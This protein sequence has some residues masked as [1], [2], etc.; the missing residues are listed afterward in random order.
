MTQD[1][2]CED[3]SERQLGALVASLAA[4]LIEGV[5]NVAV[6]PAEPVPAGAG[7]RRI[8]E[9]ADLIKAQ[10]AAVNRTREVAESAARVSEA[11]SKALDAVR[12]NLEKTRESQ[13]K[14]RDTADKTRTAAEA[15]RTQSEKLALVAERA[16]T[17]AN[18]A[19]MESALAKEAGTQAS[20]LAGKTLQSIEHLNGISG[21][22]RSVLTSV[23][24]L[25]TAAEQTQQA[26]TRNA[27]TSAELLKLAE[28][29]RAAASNTLLT[30][31]QALRVLKE[32]DARRSLSRRRKITA[33][34]LGGLAAATLATAVTLSALDGAYVGPC[35]YG[36]MTV[37]SCALNFSPGYVSIGY[38]LSALLA[39]A[40]VAVLAV[41][42]PSGS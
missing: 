31:E 13:D 20:L 41:P 6:R 9:L 15:T 5:P 30:A 3:C 8:G 22:L 35:Q 4:R 28:A 19:A 18:A 14:L 38:T 37:P 7:E 29:Q 34:I 40:T 25:R 10:G 36:S 33:G 42:S 17:S 11:S 32:R 12:A 27:T 26:A 39:A 1:S 24:P 23:E 2:A 21:D 16:A